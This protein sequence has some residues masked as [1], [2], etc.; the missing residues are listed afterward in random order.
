M[1]SCQCSCQEAPGEF[2]AN[3]AK[4]QTDGQP[5]NFLAKIDS[6]KEFRVGLKRG[7]LV[8][9]NNSKNEKMSKKLGNSMEFGSFFPYFRA[10]WTL[11]P[12]L[13][14]PVANSVLLVLGPFRATS[15]TQKKLVSTHSF[16]ARNK[17]DAY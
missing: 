13:C 7:K 3:P 2:N 8:K 1:G 4:A 10:S 16:M 6:W 12:L 5:P 14:Q 17:F 11:K 9:K 15:W